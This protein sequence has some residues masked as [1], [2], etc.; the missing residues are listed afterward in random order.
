MGSDEEPLPPA[1]W[2]CS[3]WASV[4]Q[5]NVPV[6]L[7]EPTVPA[8]FTVVSERLHRKSTQGAIYHAH[9]LEGT[10]GEYQELGISV[11][12]V[13]A[14]GEKGGLQLVMFVDSDLA[15]RGGRELWGINKTMAKFDTAKSDDWHNIT[16]TTPD[17]IVQ[18][19]ASFSLAVPLPMPR[20]TVRPTTM[21]LGLDSQRQGH[22]L[23]TVAD[24]K[25]GIMPVMRH[26]VEV[27]PGAVLEPFLN[28]GA[29][30][31]QALHFPNGEFTMNAAEDLG[32]GAKVALV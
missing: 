13:K 26:Q 19:R 6:D 27:G 18:L 3:G 22:V 29:K 10:V 8:P 24:Q 25:Y 14:N 16:V 4:L 17:G 5:M 32:S 2:Q 31:T 30:I 7:A 20:I 12:T 23:K 1:P 21:S 9:Y 28:G 15:L 11:A